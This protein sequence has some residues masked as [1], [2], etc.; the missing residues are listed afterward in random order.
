LLDSGASQTAIDTQCVQALSLVSQGQGVFH[1]PTLTGPQT[2]TRYE[3]SLTLLHPQASY[4]YYGL[5]VVAALLSP[6][7]VEVL[8]GRDVLKQCLFVYDGH[9]GTWSLGF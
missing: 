6:Q 3:V 8:L 5:A 2:Y 9:G 1:T 7:G 4:T